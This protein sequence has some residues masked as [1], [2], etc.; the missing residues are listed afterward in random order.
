MGGEGKKEGGRREDRER[1]Y[2]K[3]NEIKNRLE[4][5]PRGMGRRLSLTEH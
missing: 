3:N 1:K 4:E 2:N 5:F